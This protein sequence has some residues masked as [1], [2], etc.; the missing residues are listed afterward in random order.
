MAIE[1][2]TNKSYSEHKLTEIRNK[3][4]GK[5]AIYRSE[6]Y[7]EWRK[8]YGKS[9]KASGFYSQSVR[10]KECGDHIQYRCNCGNIEPGTKRCGLRECPD[11]ADLRA[12]K[13]FFQMKRLIP[14]L[15]QKYKYAKHIILTSARYKNA[16][17]RS[18][19]KRVK[20]RQNSIRLFFKRHLINYA[21]LGTYE[22]GGK[23]QMVHIHMLVFTNLWINKKELTAIWK[24]GHIKIK[25]IRSN[26][27]VLNTCAY[28][29]RFITKGKLINPQ[30]L[31]EIHRALIK[32]RRQFTWG[33]LYGKLKIVIQSFRKRICPICSGIME[34]SIISGLKTIKLLL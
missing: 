32:M 1:L 31:L 4:S 5:K 33:D 22:F 29:V 7:Q 11:C 8:H 27:Q 34:G 12:M 13:V 2:I 24:L 25:A 28:A 21:V 15:R 6:Y 16:S 14:G 19:M 10:W 23:N 20:S 26:K 17:L 18:D 3:Y 30:K 9:L